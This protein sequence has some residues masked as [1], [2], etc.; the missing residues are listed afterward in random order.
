MFGVLYLLCWA[1]CILVGCLYSGGLSVF[2]WAICILVGH[3]Y[4]G[5]MPIVSHYFSCGQSTEI[6]DYIFQLCVHTLHSILQNV[7]FIELP[8]QP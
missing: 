4:S 3:L 2:W 7:C 8:C 5:G 6:V 1:I